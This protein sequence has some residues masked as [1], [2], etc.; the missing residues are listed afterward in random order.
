MDLTLIPARTVLV[1]IDPQ[2][3]TATTLMVSQDVRVKQR[4]ASS[5]AR[6]KQRTGRRPRRH[7]PYHG[8]PEKR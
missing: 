6:H 2:R 5:N 3:G 7:G 4:A 1:M 8:S